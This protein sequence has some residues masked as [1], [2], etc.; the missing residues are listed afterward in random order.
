LYG[1]SDKHGISIK[2]CPVNGVWSLDKVQRVLQTVL[3]LVKRGSLSAKCVL[4]FKRVSSIKHASSVK[5]SSIKRASAASAWYVSSVKCGP[6]YK[7][8]F[9]GQVCFLFWERSIF[10]TVT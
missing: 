7:V 10:K 9:L 2:Y 3:A 1:F 8:C 6:Q 5:R 4:S